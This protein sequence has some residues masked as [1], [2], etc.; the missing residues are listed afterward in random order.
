M[1]YG[2][3]ILVTAASTRDFS[4]GDKA[5]G[6][7]VARPARISQGTRR[8][9]AAHLHFEKVSRKIKWNPV[10]RKNR[11]F[12]LILLDPPLMDLRSPVWSHVGPDMTA[13]LIEPQ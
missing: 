4:M 8:L 1:S 3:N 7:P 12:R 2:V 5:A 11:A 9:S 10:N 13:E 6:L